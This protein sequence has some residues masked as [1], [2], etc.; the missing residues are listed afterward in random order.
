MTGCEARAVEPTARDIDLSVVITCYYEEQSIEEFYSRLSATLEDIGRSYELIFVDDGSTDRTYQKL[1]SIFEKDEHVS[2][3]FRFFS[4]VG[5]ANAKTPGVVAASGRAMVHIDSDL[6]LDPEELPVLLRHY[7]DGSDVVVGYRKER[8]DPLLRKIPSLL[9]NMILR[10]ATAKNLKDFGCTFRIYD[11]RLLDGFDFGPFRPWRPVPVL[12]MA[13]RVAEVPVSHHRRRYGSSG[14]TFRKLF[15][16]N[17]ENLV[18]LSER[19]FQILG[20]LCLF[21]SFLFALRILLAYVVPFAVLKNI[22]LGLVLNALVFTFLVLMAILCAMGEFVI[23]NFI[24]LQQRP[25]YVVK[26]SRSRVV[27][28]E[29]PR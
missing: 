28:A 10:R 12:R 3:I 4:N 11:R 2:A 8:K 23:R 24:L 14:W 26:D 15:A 20:T 21:F 5:Q 9:A 19:P 7:D 22:T 29:P 6:Q 18:N 25:A 27:R 17:M 13:G 16:Y 1:E